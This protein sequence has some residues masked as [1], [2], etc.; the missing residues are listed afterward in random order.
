MACSR[1][2]RTAAGEL[3]VMSIQAAAA[4]SDVSAPSFPS[5]AVRTSRGPG[6]MVISTSADEA[7][8]AGVSCQLAPHAMAAGSRSARLSVAVTI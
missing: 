1:T 3:L 4:A 5:I 7:A 6:S 8:R 2:G